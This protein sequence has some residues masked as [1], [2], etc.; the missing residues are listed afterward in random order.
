MAEGGEGGALRRENL[1]APVQ[2]LVLVIIMRYNLLSR[3]PL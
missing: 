3:Y 1:F 2:T